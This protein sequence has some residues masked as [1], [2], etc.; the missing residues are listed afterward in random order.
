MTL[1]A[2]SRTGAY[3]ILASLGADGSASARRE[4]FVRVEL[5]RDRAEAGAARAQC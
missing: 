5:P 3:E 1:A 4:T 2:G